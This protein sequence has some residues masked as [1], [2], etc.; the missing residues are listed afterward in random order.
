LIEKFLFFYLKL[1]F[2][3]FLI[4]KVFLKKKILI[5]IKY[6]KK[7]ALI[8]KN[9]IKNNNNINKIKKKKKNI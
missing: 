3:R 1:Y 2:D 8:G 6:E 5:L 9:F 4:Y 7:I